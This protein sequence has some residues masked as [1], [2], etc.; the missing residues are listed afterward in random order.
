MG[1]FRVLGALVD[2]NNFPHYMLS[3]IQ[4]FDI[5]HAA[6]ILT[7]STIQPLSCPA[8]N[9]TSGTESSLCTDSPIG[10]TVVDAPIGKRNFR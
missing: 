6:D 9:T 1:H 7:N 2:P 4:T 10:F 5:R 3:S 8:A